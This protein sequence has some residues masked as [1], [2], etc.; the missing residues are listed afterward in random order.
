[1]RISR[2]L[3]L[4]IWFSV[5]A[6]AGVMAIGDSFVQKIQGD[7]TLKKAAL[8]VV[9]PH[10]YGVCL[11]LTVLVTASEVNG[12]PLNKQQTDALGLLSGAMFYFRQYQ[13]AKGTPEHVLDGIW[14]PYKDE[15]RRIGMQAYFSKYEKYCLQ[16][17]LDF[18]GVVQREK[19]TQNARGSVQSTPPVG[20]DQSFKAAV[21]DLAAKQS[22]KPIKKQAGT[23]KNIF[24]G[25]CYSK[26]EGYLA[27]AIGEEH[28]AFAYRTEPNGSVI[29][30]ASSLILPTV[31]RA[32]RNAET[33][34]FAELIE[35][36]AANE[37]LKCEVYD[38]Q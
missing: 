2:L 4:V 29:Y 23:K 12:A 6:F 10:V 1:M 16:K 19:E 22:G 17:A 7:E 18:V 3:C 9:T 5:P 8:T 20:G 36:A 13:L 34:C 31:D 21:G 24:T 35:A 15:S 25:Q 26:Y 33:K 28:K 30:C 14:A 11:P 37:N 38:W 27:L 32:K